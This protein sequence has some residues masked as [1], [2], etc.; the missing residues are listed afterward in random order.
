MV[1]GMRIRIRKLTTIP[2]DSPMSMVKPTPRR[3]R[4]VRPKQ[5]GM[6]FPKA[7]RSV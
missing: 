1:M 5:M 7:F 6:D 2:T 3:T 4:I